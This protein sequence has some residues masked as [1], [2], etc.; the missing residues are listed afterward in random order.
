MDLRTGLVPSLSFPSKV[1]EVQARA[2]A[3]ELQETLD[4]APDG[5]VIHLPSGTYNLNHP[6]IIKSGKK[7]KIQG[8]GVLFSTCLQA[9][10]D[11]E[12]DALVICQPT[13]GLVLEDL[14]IGSVAPGGGPA[15]LLIQVRD[16]P[17]VAVHGD[18]I[19]SYGFG[20]GLVVQ[21]L[22]EARVLLENHGHNGVT[23]FGGSGSKDW[24][25][26]EPFSSQ[27]GD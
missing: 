23:V 7:I 27:Q 5:A 3:E 16:E 22:D 19:Q 18:Q 2:N 13:D 4:A 25:G 17:G 6:L 12:G 8:D 15:G 24:T 10:G 14:Q 26:P 11:F 1:I 20:P 9:A 21:G